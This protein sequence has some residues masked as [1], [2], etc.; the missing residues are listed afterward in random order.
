MPRAAK[1]QVGT[2]KRP[3]SNQETSFDH[4]APNETS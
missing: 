3:R 1:M 2:K 4:R